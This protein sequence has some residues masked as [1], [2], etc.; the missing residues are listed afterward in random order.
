MKKKENGKNSFKV[1]Q[2][3]KELLGIDNPETNEIDDMEGLEGI[4]DTGIIEVN[5]T[6]KEPD[7]SFAKENTASNSGNGYN[8]PASS[9]EAELNTGGNYQ[10][11]FVDPKTF[12][13]CK[14][15]AT[16]IKNDKMVTLNLEYLDLPTAQRLMDFL[17][18]AMSIKGSSFIEISKKVYTAVPK[19]MKVY[20]EGK[21]DSRGRTILDFGR[22][23]K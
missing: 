12:A 21:K 15:I 5:S 23:E 11:I 22:E 4:D 8:K 1:F 20:Y 14:K 9:L 13:D 6:G 7:I 16:Y 17:A 2:D 18:G 10:T 19:S 3:L